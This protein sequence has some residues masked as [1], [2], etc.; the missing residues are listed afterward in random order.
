METNKFS[1]EFDDKPREKCGV[2]GIYGGNE[3]DIGYRT[4]EALFQLDHRGDQA[5]GITI[6]EDGKPVTTKDY[7][8]VEQV[9][10]EANLNALPSGHISVGHVRYATVDIDNANDAESNQPIAN[11]TFALAH[12]GNFTRFNGEWFEGNSHSDSVHFYNLLSELRRQEPN[13]ELKDALKETAID[14]DGAF[15]LVVAD[16]DQLVAIRDPHGFRPLFWGQHEDGWYTV[17]SESVV[18]DALDIFD[19]QMIPRGSLL[20]IDAAGAKLESYDNTAPGSF[21]M[22]EFV[23][24]SRPDTMYGSESVETRRERSGIQLAIEH[25]AEADVVVGVPGTGLPAAKG[26]AEYLGIP[27]KI[28]GI[29]KKGSKRSFIKRRQAERELTTKRKLNITRDMVE[30]KRVVVV[31]DSVVRGT[32]AGV[33]VNKLRNFGATEVHYRVACPPYINTCHTGI[34]TGRPEELIARNMS[35]EEI[36]QAI[37]LDS[38]GYLSLEGL[39]QALKYDLEDLCDACVSGNY[40]IPVKIGRLATQAR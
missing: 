11:D 23:Y 15:S 4:F 38:L 17:A 19:Y 37:N 32:V 29:H 1:P 12:N 26:Y 25:P 21:C 5:A 20:T 28:G 7:G 6:I 40:P 33:I 31:D 9:F 3:A 24:F 39:K 35:Q 36:R 10:D 13:L 2:V 30:G 22:M 34:D 27:Y 14:S 16:K 8:E 18:M